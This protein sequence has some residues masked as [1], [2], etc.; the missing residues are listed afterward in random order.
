[1]EKQ[2]EHDWL[3]YISFLGFLISFA[4]F[5]VTSGI[6]LPFLDVA[7]RWDGSNLQITFTGIAEIIVAAGFAIG[8]ILRLNRK[9][10]KD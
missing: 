1:M 2:R 7:M 3:L 6:V 5:I 9:E 8:I 4:L 10:R